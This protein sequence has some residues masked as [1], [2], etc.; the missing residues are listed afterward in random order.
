[1][2]TDMANIVNRYKVANK[3][4][5][6]AYLHMTLSHSKHE[7]QGHVQFNCQYLANGDR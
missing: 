7:G 2:V 6:L 3:A 5:S 1:M 4:F